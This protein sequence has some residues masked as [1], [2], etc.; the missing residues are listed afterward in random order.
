LALDN[1][2]QAGP[3]GELRA[4]RTGWLQY[5]LGKW[6]ASIFAYRNALSR[7]P[8][9]MDARLGEVLSLLAAQ[10]WGEAERGAQAALDLE[11]NNYTALLRLAVAQEAQKN[12]NGLGKTGTLLTTYYPSDYLSYLYLARAHAWLGKSSDAAKA[13]GAVLSR[14]PGYLEAKSYLE[15]R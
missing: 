13:Y 3:D 8:H 5:R 15:K 1:V 12:W 14:Y 11:P 9:S 7:N 4:L 6:D 2:P 10:R